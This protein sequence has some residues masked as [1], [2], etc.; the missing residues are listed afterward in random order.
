MNDATPI[1]LTVPPNDSDQTKDEVEW[2]TYALHYDVMC[3]LNPAYSDLVNAVVE[4]VSTIDLPKQPRVLDVG[5]GTGNLICSIHDQVPSASF[6][7][8]DIDKEMSRLARSKYEH[9]GVTAEILTS[10]FGT[11]ELPLDDFDV[12]VSTNALYAIQPYRETLRKIRRL[13]KSNGRFIAVDFGRPINT[14]DWALYI[15]RQAIKKIGVR[16]TLDAF[17][18]HWDAVRQNRRVGKAQSQGSFWVHD[19]KQ[20]GDALT[21]ADF[22]V[23]ELIS[24]YRGYSDL[25]VC[26]PAGAT[27]D[28]QR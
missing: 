7:H 16:A 4:R 12:V 11:A 26:Q 1:Q 2:S 23:T 14:T 22:K 19:T 13:I 8:V 28:T 15:G 27:S 10:P 20:F 25:A 5:A 21:E 24:C 3:S 6:V 17:L 18:S 9:H